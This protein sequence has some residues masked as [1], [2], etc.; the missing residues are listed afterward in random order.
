MQSQD[1]KQFA[2]IMATLAE[3]FNDGKEVS[4]I[5]M[6]IYFKALEKY[7]IDHISSAISE[8]IKSRVY[9][10]FPKPAEI[11]QEITGKEENRAIQAWLIAFDA[12]GRVGNYE[13]VKFADTAI[14]SVIQIMGG[15]PKFCMMENH[16]VTWKQKEFE[17]LYEVISSQS[18][19]H[20]EYLPG[21]HEIENFRLG[22]EYKANVV[23]IGFDKK[24]IRMI[25]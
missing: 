3:V 4:K 24:Q 16:E 22:R 8:M 9:P 17:R 12:V 7:P 14:H 1:H 5:K 11:I 2:V 13:S 10:S 23:R 6:E 15:W 20:P 21:T 19:K 25:Q 18:G